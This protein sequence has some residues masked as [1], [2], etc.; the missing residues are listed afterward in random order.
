MAV[1]LYGPAIALSSVTPISITT[2][3]VV[4]GTICTFYTSIGGIKA[5][6][7]TDVLQCFLMF[8]GVAIVIVQGIIELGGISPALQILEDGGRLKLFKLVSQMYF[9]YVSE[10]NF[11]LF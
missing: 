6:I 2:S 7:W 9:Y 1:V 5:V 3:I 11:V 10:F 8:L 4:V